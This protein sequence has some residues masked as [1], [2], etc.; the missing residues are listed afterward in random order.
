MAQDDDDPLEGYFG[1]S[2]SLGSLGE[3][4]RKLGFE[5]VPDNAIRINK[6]WYKTTR[7]DP[8]DILISTLVDGV[9]SWQKGRRGNEILS[10]LKKS[11]GKTAMEK[12]VLRS[13]SD[14]V[15]AMG[16]EGGGFQTT[17]WLESALTRYIPGLYSQAARHWDENIYDTKTDSMGKNV[18]IK[19]GVG[20]PFIKGEKVVGLW[21]QYAKSDK[22]HFFIPDT[23]NAE[24]FK[25]NLAFQ[26]W[27]D[28]HVDDKH[29]PMEFG[30]GYTDED[31]SKVKFDT[32][33]KSK[34]HRAAGL[35]AYKLVDAFVPKIHT[36]SPDKVTLEVIDSLRSK[37]KAIVVARFKEHGDF[38]VSNADPEIN[39]MVTT[40]YKSPLVR[41]D[42]YQYDK[43]P[44]KKGG[45]YEDQ[46][47]D[48][49]KF[50]EMK[51]GAKRYREWLVENWAIIS[52]KIRQ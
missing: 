50:N 35:L 14:F 41:E 11:A 37:A 32:A 19:A 13:V 29:Q 30:D 24:M 3:K 8:F 36:E 18:L 45:K 25:G 22:K 31:G 23:R 52:G 4:K 49:E 5:A 39:K 26:K 44:T 27:N 10:D 2:G 1:L 40:I 51:A 47:A 33:D 16:E 12:S 15:D 48:M 7:V 9:K 28:K 34:F 21:G 20:W 38:M 6:T 43:Q 17:D 42:S 46:P